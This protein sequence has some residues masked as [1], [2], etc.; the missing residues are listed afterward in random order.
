VVISGAILVAALGAV[1]VLAAWL[2][3]GIFLVSRGQ[4]A[5]TGG[6]AAGLS[7][8]AAGLGRRAAGF[9]G[10]AAGFGWRAGGRAPDE[11]D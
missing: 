2:V 5:A 10:R 4:S 3:V 6:R 1:A 9:G 8:R 11:P 7:G